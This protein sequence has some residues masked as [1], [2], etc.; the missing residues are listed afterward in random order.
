LLWFVAAAAGVLAGAGGAVAPSAGEASVGGASA[1]E[2]LARA[3]G[4]IDR[5]SARIDELVRENAELREENAQLVRVKEE[6]RGLVGGQA[7]RLAEANETLAVL[8]RMVFGRKS[9]KD[10]PEPPGGAGAG[11]DCAGDGEGEPSGGRKK[12]ERGPGARAGRRDYS[13]L[14]RVE[15]IWDFPG[16]G[17]CCPGCGEP[18]T[19]MGSDHV[20][21]VLDWKVLVTVAAHCRRRYKRACRCPGPL[22]VTAPGPPR[23]IGKGLFTNGFIAMLLAERFAAGRSQNSLVTGLARH[24][25][26]ISPAT[27]A[28]TVAQ[29]AGLL[30]PLAGAIAERNRESW[31]FRADETTWRVFCPGEGKGPARFWL[32]VFIGA[33]TVCF[34]MDPSRPGKVLARHAGI[35]EETGQ[36][37]PAADGG[38]RRLVISSDFYAVYQSAGRKAGGLVTLYCAAHIRRHMVR[39]GD[40][41]PVQLTYWTQNWLVLFRDLYKAHDELMAAWQEAAAPPAREKNAAAERLES[42]YGDWDASTGVID[43]TRKKQAQ[44]PGL[45]EPAKKA[46]ATLDREWDGLIAHRDY[47]MISLDNNLAERTIRGPVVT[48]KN[49]GRSRNGQTAGNAAVIWTVT[50]TAQMAALNLITY[51]TACLG[52]C[53]RNGGKP[54]SGKALERFLPWK[55]GPEDL[56]A[57]AQPPPPG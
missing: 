42:A 16:G 25:A 56:R 7:A 33:D 37:L 12:A 17:Y 31:H 2:L 26:E 32:R 53:G 14:P 1:E 45:A 55:A 50:A 24:G 18:F 19:G 35:G 10:R 30:A 39:A 46:L 11:D 48:R 21:E 9:E 27:L 51:L 49:A 52:E 28:G 54:L 29:A 40:A 34:V 23:A 20:T 41:S 8:Q 47:P 57:W 38:P 4:V 22:T 3:L 15:V 5:Q 36:L 43:A 44:A 13:D 6:L